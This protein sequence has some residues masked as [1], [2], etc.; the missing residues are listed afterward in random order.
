MKTFK[1]ALCMT[2]ALTLSLSAFASCNEPQDDGFGK[3]K[4]VSPKTVEGIQYTYEL[5]KEDKKE[6]EQ[7]VKKCRTLTLDGTDVEAIEAAWEELLDKYY[8]IST[9]GNLAYLMS[10]SDNKDKELSGN[11]K[12]ASKLQGDAYEMYVNLCVEIYESESPYKEE[13]FKDWTAADIQ[14]ILQY[15]GEINALRES[16][17]EILVEYRELDEADL[18][19]ATPDLYKRLVKNN[20]A[21]AAHYDYDT[22][23]E[24]AYPN[25]YSR[26]YSTENIKNMR[27]YV[28]KYLAPLADDLINKYFNAE[29]KMNAQES[30]AFRQFTESRY[31]EAKAGESTYLD[32]YVNSLSDSM[33]SGL[34]HAFENGNFY[35]ADGDNADEGAF[36]T[37]LYSEDCSFAYFGPG[38][39]STLTVV[40]ELGHYYAGLHEGDNSTS[41][42]LAETQSQGNEWLMLSYLETVMES[43]AL[44]EALLSYQMY[45]FLATIVVSTIVDEFEEYIYLSK[46]RIDEYTSEQ[47]DSVMTSVCSRY[48]GLTYIS[49][50]LTDV[51]S[52]WRYV[53]L[54]QPVYYISYATSAIA[55]LN[56]YALAQE[57]YATATE[58]YRKLVE[59]V[60][61]EKGFVGNLEAVG[62]ASPFEEE[63]Y[64]TL[65]TLL[66]K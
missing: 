11:Y 49:N 9:Q 3:L 19:N 16:N 8:Y 24:Y 29:K 56:L 47:I 55:A 31:D 42:D 52:Y 15:S 58:A 46:D 7:L 61:Y 28:G 32:L 41:F 38:Y 12:F 39:N 60:D 27:K 20:N 54:E 66:L 63:T 10:C 64:K 17:D 21:I 23:Y 6:F 62:L 26:D 53:V 1:K 45:S 37:S 43:E 65:K 25:V 34:N 18:K 50:Y 35:F 36:V 4:S 13:F 5:R 2:L 59:E 44:Y 30:V 57:D 22:Y 51:H 14:A 33:K 40:H 48:G